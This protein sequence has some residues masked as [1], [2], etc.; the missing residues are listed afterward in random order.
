MREVF[1]S[2][3]ELYTGRIVPD[4]YPVNPRKE[5]DHLATLVYWH[6]RNVLG[7]YMP[8]QEPTEYL[9]LR[10][11]E[12]DSRAAD[13]LGAAHERGRDISGLLNKALAKHFLVLPYFA[14]IHSGVTISLGRFSCPWDSG[15]A[16]LAIVKLADIRREFP[17]AE[18]VVEQ[19][20]KVIEWEIEEFDMY[21][22]GD[23][24]AY[25]IEREEDGETV[26]SVGG[27]YDYDNAVHELCTALDAI[28][29]NVGG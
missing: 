11:W 13:V 28:E 20:R 8:K 18:D 16:G 14:Y 10:L 26:D 7:D 5:F 6:H 2:P 24:W 3:S 29:G 19:A 15:Q 1:F 22:R 25:T 23:V 21:V 9:L 12:V 4:E 17:D 27:I